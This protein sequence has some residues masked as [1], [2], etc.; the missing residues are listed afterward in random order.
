MNKIK[1]FLIQALTFTIPVGF[2]SAQIPSVTLTQSSI[3][4]ILLRFRDWVT[5]V[6]AILTV[7][8]FLW[9]AVKFMTAG[10]NEEEVDKAKHMFKYGLIG[11]AVA[12]VA[13]TVFP[14]V[15]SF[16]GGQ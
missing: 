4:D 11:V 1:Y 8:L 2:A 10:G 7:V 13:Y 12:I 5:G 15:S 6:V 9:A 16:L 3:R 14:L